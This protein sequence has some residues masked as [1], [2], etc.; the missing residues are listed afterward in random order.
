MSGALEKQFTPS[1]P[2]PT[3]VGSLPFGTPLY[4]SQMVAD[5]YTIPYQGLH[6]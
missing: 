1:A 2:L 5:P 6:A 3:W 4:L